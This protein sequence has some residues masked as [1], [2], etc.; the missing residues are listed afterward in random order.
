MAYVFL[1][2]ARRAT[3]LQQDTG[4]PRPARHSESTMGHGQHPAW[5]TDLAAIRPSNDFQPSFL[6][7]FSLNLAAD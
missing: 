3:L 4:Y 1:A 6:P 2:P 7:P 5:A